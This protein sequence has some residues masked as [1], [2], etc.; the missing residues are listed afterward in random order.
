MKVD[1]KIQLQGHVQENEQSQSGELQN[2][3]KL[4]EA[5]LPQPKDYDE[6]EY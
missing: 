6:I 2:K 5:P 4:S 3:K 1:H